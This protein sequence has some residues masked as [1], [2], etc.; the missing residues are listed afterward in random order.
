MTDEYTPMGSEEALRIALRL[1]LEA[2]AGKPHREDS[3]RLTEAA[4]TIETIL[5]KRRCTH[6]GQPVFGA[7]DDRL[8]SVIDAAISEDPPGS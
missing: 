6:N 5:E 7:I 8:V 4:L 3:L 1:V 2:H